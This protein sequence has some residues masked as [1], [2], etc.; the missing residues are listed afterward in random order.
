MGGDRYWLAKK[1]YG[2]LVLWWCGT[3]KKV[4]P[5][6]KRLHRALLEVTAGR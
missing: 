4:D 5:V 6:F 2:N 1:R 3:A